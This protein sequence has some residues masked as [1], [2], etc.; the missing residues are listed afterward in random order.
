[1]NAIRNHFQ[2]FSPFLKLILLIILI[3]SGLIVAIIIGFLVAIPFFGTDMLSIL[4]QS[5]ELTD[6]RQIQIMKYFQI[7]SHLGM[8]IIP[9]FLFAHFFENGIKKFF[10]FNRKISLLLI[11]MGGLSIVLMLPFVHFL[12]ELNSSISFPESMKGI[13]NWIKS[14]EETAEIAIMAFLSQTSALA[15]IVNF[16]MIA[17][18]PAIGEE[19]IFRGII[20]TKLKQWFGNIHVAV[21]VSS[22][23]FSAIHMQFYGFLPRVFLGML[24]G[25]LFVWSGSLWVPMLAHLVNNGLAV[26]MSWFFATNTIEGDIKNFGNMSE[27]PVSVIAISAMAFVAVMFFRYINKKAN[28]H[29]LKIL[30][31]ET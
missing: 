15:F 19:L 9:S 28:P 7:I 24:L 29:Y 14:S 10:F 11:I 26:V 4:S 27:H 6:P 25:Y 18:I 12:G 16:L 1:M 13:E 23:I 8:F 3:F 30:Q 17:I 31:N 2:E 20:L 21:I 5:H 22:I